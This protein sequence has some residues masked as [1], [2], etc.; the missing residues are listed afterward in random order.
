M[1]PADSSARTNVK[2]IDLIPDDP[3]LIAWVRESGLD[4]KCTEIRDNQ[5]A[6]IIGKYMEAHPEPAPTL[7]IVAS[8]AEPAPMAVEH[9]TVAHQQLVVSSQHPMMT[10][11]EAIAAVNWRP[12][13]P[14]QLCDFLLD[15][16]EY[17]EAEIERYGTPPEPCTTLCSG[18]ESLCE[19]TPYESVWTR[20]EFEAGE[21]HEDL[22]KTKAELAA[23]QARCDN[24]PAVIN[25]NLPAVISHVP[26]VFS[27]TDYKTGAVLPTATN[28]LTALQAVGVTAALDTFSNELLVKCGNNI[29]TIPAGTTSNDDDHTV[30]A[31]T[32][33]LN[34]QFEVDFSEHTVHRAISAMGYQNR[35]DPIIE[36]LRKAELDY[37]GVQR[38]ETF[39]VEY[40]NCADTPL[41]R[42]IGRLMICAAVRRARRHGC[43]CDFIFVL[44][45]EQGYYKSEFFKIMAGGDRYF[46]QRRLFDARPQEVQEAMAQIWWH[47]NQ[48]LE[49]LKTGGIEKVTAFLSTTHDDGRPAYG[50]AAIHQ[51]RKGIETGSTNDKEFLM[52][53]TGNRRWQCLEVLKPID[54]EKIK[55]DRLQLL[56]EAAAL[57]KANPSERFLELPE[58]LWAEAAKM[59][60][61]RRVVDPIEDCLANIPYT[62]AADG[63]EKVIIHRID[64]QERVA[65]DDLFNHVLPK[66]TGTRTKAQS[67]PVN[68]AMNKHGWTRPDN[69][70]VWIKGR[71]TAG[72]YR[73]IPTRS[74]A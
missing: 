25:N 42:A 69:R 6:F 71:R 44:I 1:M 35:F 22:E 34:R 67:T 19:A 64:G 26:A 62:V 68:K 72:F 50:H 27:D 41:N 38:L 60:E 3:L 49:G 10:E 23:A 5:R 12:K 29:G 56:G 4:P 32:F 73:S 48:E 17:L 18:C 45:S 51:A 70:M 54:I 57:E 13:D 40:L 55:R 2:V 16:V 28:A 47:E 7:E 58:E 9:T 21:L 33:G 61:S 24:L 39:A 66:L 74:D 65:T 8:V 46:S 37:D 31:I 15:Q 43:K 20:E 52:K 11:E 59:Q 30:R 14:F 53:D 36:E 63:V